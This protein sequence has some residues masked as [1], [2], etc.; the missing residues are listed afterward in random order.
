[1][2][3]VV[4]YKE[5]T[6]QN[7]K[8]DSARYIADYAIQIRFNDGTERVVDF[9]PFLS[10]ALH[11][12]IKKYLDKNKFSNYKITDG[13]LNWD[14]FDMIFPIWDLYNGKIEA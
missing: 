9:K 10:K 6:V 13:N 4:H 8:V 1:M 11:P 12:S 3:I 14:D 7:I 2:R 5:N